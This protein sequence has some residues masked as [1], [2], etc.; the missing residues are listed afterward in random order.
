MEGSEWGV[1]VQYDNG[2]V[3]IQLFGQASCSDPQ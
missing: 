3:Y 1:G 2:G